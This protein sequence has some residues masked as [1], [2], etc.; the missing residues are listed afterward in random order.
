MLAVLDQVNAVRFD[1]LSLRL[2]QRSD[3]LFAYGLWIAPRHY[4]GTGAKLG[5]PAFQNVPYAL[6]DSCGHERT[7]VHAGSYLQHRRR[8]KAAIASLHDSIVKV[9]VPVA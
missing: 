7:G 4:Y 9:R 3:A 8:Q 6:S 2:A 1:Y 5:V